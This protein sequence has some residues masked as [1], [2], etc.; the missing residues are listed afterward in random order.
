MC[1]I[2][3]KQPATNATKTVSKTGM[4]ATVASA[5]HNDSPK[6]SRRCLKLPPLS[7][8]ISG[9]LT[10][11]GSRVDIFRGHETFPLAQHESLY[12]RLRVKVLD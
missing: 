12:R 9:R 8:Y 11:S 10:N 3:V 4:A 2:T 5:I 1:Q 7:D 6:S